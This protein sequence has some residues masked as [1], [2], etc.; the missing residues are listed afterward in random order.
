MITTCQDHSIIPFFLWIFILIANA[1]NII[2]KK[3][4]PNMK[5]MIAVETIIA[6]QYADILYYYLF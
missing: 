4:A 3:R 1:I 5:I 6:T 2:K